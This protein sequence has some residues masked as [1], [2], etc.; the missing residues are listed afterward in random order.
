MLRHNTVHIAP[1]LS[2]SGTMRQALNLQ[3]PSC[4]LAFDDYISVG[5]IQVFGSISEWRR[6]RDGYWASLPADPLPLSGQYERAPFDLYERTEALPKADT[7]VLWI[8]T[9]LAEQLL[10]VWLLQLL[11][12]LAVDPGR[13]AIIQ[14]ER[15]GQQRAEVVGIGILNPDQLRAHPTARPLDPAEI[16]ELDAAWAALV[17]PD[18]AG[19]LSLL[20]S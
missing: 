19:L 11:R 5:P 16:A 4:L 12:H 10:L 8:G 1:G 7:I 9:G 6:L 15:F 13:L 3:L 2:A 14:Y 20:A 18:P 17:S